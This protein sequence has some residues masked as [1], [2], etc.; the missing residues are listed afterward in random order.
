M[1]STVFNKANAR[2]MKKSTQPTPAQSHIRP[3]F[4]RLPKPR[5]N[6]P[7]TGYSRT[8]L[9]DLTVPC[10]ANNFRPAVPAKCEK[11]R[12]NTRGTWLVPFDALIEHI[13]NLPTPGLKPRDE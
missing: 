1:G 11:K 8:G 4:I 3:I 7:Y 9:Y 12:G 13:T 2:S 10:K 6:C 5:T